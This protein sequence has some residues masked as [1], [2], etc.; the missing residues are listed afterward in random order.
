MVSH[1]D[2]VY[3]IGGRQNTAIAV[4]A[5]G[6]GDVT[7]SHLLWKTTA[8]SNVS[9]PVYRDGHL[10]WVH[11]SRGLAYCL[12]ADT[13]EIVYQERLDP[14]PGLI[15]SSTTNGDGKLYA[16]SRENGSYVIAA[17]PEFK[18]LAVNSFS[19]DTAR[20]NG[21]IAVSGSRL[22]LRTDRAIY[23]IGN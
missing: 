18:L 4:R 10:Y 12:A 8:G 23:C 2:V 15:Y 7:D 19:D 11:D 9:S 14:R 21:S 3:A 1:G 5:G 20:A 22:I 6:K 17:Q 13:G 16:I